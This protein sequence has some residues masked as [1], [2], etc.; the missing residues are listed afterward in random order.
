MDTG[1]AY[2]SSSSLLRNVCVW[3]M[4]VQVDHVQLFTN[5][6]EVYSLK[7]AAAGT[8]DYADVTP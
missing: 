5:K 6:R 3:R 2:S 4:C 1:V 7:D 8:W